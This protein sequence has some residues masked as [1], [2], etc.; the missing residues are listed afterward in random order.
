MGMHGP[1]RYCLMDGMAVGD[2]ASMLRVKKG[3]VYMHVALIVMRWPEWSLHP[4]PVVWVYG[5]RGQLVVATV[6]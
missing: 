6:D 1:S 2:W 5:V 3:T 4:P